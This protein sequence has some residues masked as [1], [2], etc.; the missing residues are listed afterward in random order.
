MFKSYSLFAL[1]AA[2]VML[3]ATCAASGANAAS[4]SVY[5]YG[6][7][8]VAVAPA[9]RPYV[10]PRGAV[11]VAPRCVSRAQRA[12]IDGRPVSRTVR[13]CV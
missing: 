1:S 8:P 5:T 7:R 12:W 13:H 3:A 6:P 9:Y 11:V 10:A 2:S 4:V